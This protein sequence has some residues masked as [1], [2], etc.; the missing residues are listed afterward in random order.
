MLTAWAEAMQYSTN[1][2]APDDQVLD[3]LL[4][5]GGWL[6]RVSLGWLPTSYLRTMPAYYRGIDPV[7]DHDR[8]TAPGVAGHS[9]VKPKL[10]PVIWEESVDPAEVPGEPPLLK[11][12]WNPS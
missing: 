4:N 6:G 7:I 12:G 5:E 11:P 9:D 10:P 3:K 1:A 2:Q 8:G